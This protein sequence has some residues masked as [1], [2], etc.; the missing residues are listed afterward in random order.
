MSKVIIIGGGVVGLCTAWHLRQA[1]MQV[2]VIDRQDSS[3]GCSHGNA[4]M[5]V[6]SHFTPLASPGMIAKGIGWMFQKKSPFFIRPRLDMDLLKWLWLFYRSANA[7]HVANCAPLL[8]DLHQESRDQ[9]EAWNASG[10][11]SFDF[12]RQGILMLYQTQAAESDELQAADMADALGIT[13]T[14][15]N[16]D[17]AN[18]LEPG[19]RLNIR[20]AV[21][22]P[23]DAHL[24]PDVFMRQMKAWLLTRQVIFTQGVDVRGVREEAGKVEC[25]LTDDAVL[26]ADAL[27]VAAGAWSGRLM[28]S[29]GYPLPM[30]DGKGYS[31]TYTG[32]TA[33]PSIPS[34][35]HE[36]RV[37]VTPMG[38]RLRISGT[39]EISGMDDR[40]REHKVNSIREAIPAY[41]EDMPLP[42]ASPAWF[43]YRP[44]TPDGMPYVGRLSKG[45][46]IVLATG[47]AMMGLSLAPATGRLVRDILEGKAEAPASL[48]PSRYGR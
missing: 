5:I 45:S 27:I 4:G 46:S 40:I 38:G 8:R 23:G 41:Y 30:Q 25:V 17:Q 21:H 26:Q 12:S 11:F 6:P 28:K 31:F 43:G 16:R 39:L 29:S 10:D 14:P 2:T 15:L 42:A 1:G 36:A 7:T 13:A 32:L 20:G 47:H 34:I 44:C 33:M 35:L 19:C 48:N 18:Q 9:Y 37:A 24:S 22:Y 3:D